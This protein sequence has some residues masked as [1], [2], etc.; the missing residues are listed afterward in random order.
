MSA[1]SFRD[2][3]TAAAA[4][5]DRRDAHVLADSLRTD[6]RAFR[7]LSADEPLVIEL[8]EFSRMHEEISRERV[9]LTNRLR[10][11]IRRYFPAFLDV[12]KDPG[13]AFSQALF[14]LVP[15]PDRAQQV[16]PY[17]IA[18][19]LKEHR[20]RR[21]E[22][23]EVLAKLREPKLIVADGTTTAAIAHIHLLH[24][25]L[26]MLIQ[27]QKQVQKSIER[28]LQD[29]PRCHAQS[30]PG[31]AD[32]TSS[33]SELPQ[34]NRS[35]QRDAAIL[36]SIPGVGRTI[37]ATLLAEG[38]RLI[39][40]RDY[41][42]LRALSG[43]APVTRSSGK[44]LTV[45][46]R[47]ACHGRLRNAM[48]AWAFVAMQHDPKSKARYQELRARGATIGRALRTVADRLLRIACAMLRDQSM[49]DPTAH[50]SSAAA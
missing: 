31:D 35:A 25:R 23:A 45:A 41:Q 24:E 49:W 48:H 37:V 33:D 42:G 10:E 19:L 15:T 7:R 2:R 20:I 50:D 8:R 17:R 3:F 47:K 43:I 18:K 9:Q 34:S 13:D 28:L 39:A 46:M 16:K 12:A 14:R 21:I 27:Q 32:A 36:L 29:S 26:A 30:E 22:A 4:K 40:L 38:S 5:D 11:Q 6:P 1:D 44:R